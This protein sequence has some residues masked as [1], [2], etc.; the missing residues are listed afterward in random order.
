MTQPNSQLFPVPLYN[1]TVPDKMEGSKGLP[2]P[3]AWSVGPATQSI[4]MTLI[5]QT[6]KISGVQSVFIDNGSN[7][8]PVTI[9]VSNTVQS[10][11]LP[12]GYQGVFPIFATDKTVFTV[13]SAGT[14]SSQVIF[15][16]IAMNYNIWPS[17]ASPASVLTPL[18]TSD[19]ILDACVVAL[20]LNV[21]SIN[22]QITDADHSGQIA[23]A[24][25]AQV[26]AVADATR[27]GWMLQNI[28]EAILE[29]FW[30]CTTGVAVVGGAGSFC[31]AA[32]AGA[33]YPGGFVQGQSSNAISVIA[34]SA[35][36][37]FSLITF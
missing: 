30:Y 1:G 28:D 34:T 6:G 17:S 25:S 24:N 2:V 31:L 16:N 7:D 29:D 22:A 27:R 12:A 11:S 5:R 32:S 9:M 14:G 18:P 15:L 3:F 36:H 8:A 37:K 13:A 20:R 10:I 21:R 26:A 35:N 23:V 19:A 4:D 33:G